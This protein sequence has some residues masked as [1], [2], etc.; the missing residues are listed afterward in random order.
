M[1]T[2]DLAILHV[3]REKHTA[4]SLF[5]CSED[6]GIPKRKPVKTVQIDRGENVCDFGSGDVELGEQFDFA[7]GNAPSTCNCRVTV[8]K[9]S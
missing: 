1:K 2:V 4:P 6:Q 7:T 5:G 3:L 8:T 9:Y